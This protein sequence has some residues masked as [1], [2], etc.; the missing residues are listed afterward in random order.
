MEKW[1]VAVLFPKSDN[2]EIT[3][4]KII[5]FVLAFMATI[6][7]VLWISKSYS[8]FY[9]NY[10][11]PFGTFFGFFFLISLYYFFYGI[12]VLL[13]NLLVPKKKRR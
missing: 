7:I 9:V 6:G 11:D 13:M 4:G 2:P 1:L 8:R 3:Y 10:V 5:Q 12:Q